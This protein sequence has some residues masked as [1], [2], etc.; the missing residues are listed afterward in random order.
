MSEHTPLVSNKIKDE[1]AA[2]LAQYSGVSKE[3]V[4]NIEELILDRI[5]N[6]LD[7]TKIDNQPLKDVLKTNGFTFI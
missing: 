6:I 4:Q 1:Y 3:E 7:E 5:K 2:L